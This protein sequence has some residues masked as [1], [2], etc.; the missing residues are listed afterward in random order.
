MNL[1]TENHADKLTPIQLI[2]LKKEIEG[3]TG[4]V[5]SCMSK[6]PKESLLFSLGIQ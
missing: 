3:N 2:D 6:K 1:L 5:F 4:G